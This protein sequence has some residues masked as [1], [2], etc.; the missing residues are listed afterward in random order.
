MWWFPD[1]EF[2]NF[3][4]TLASLV[5]QLVKNLLAMGETWAAKVL[6]RSPR[7]GTSYPLQYSALDNSMD[8]I[9]K[10]W[11]GPSDFHFLSQP[12]CVD[13]YCMKIAS[14]NY[15][16]YTLKH[17]EIE[18]M[19][20]ESIPFCAF[21]LIAWEDLGINFAYSKKNHCKRKNLHSLCHF[22]TFFLHLISF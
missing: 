9:A 15:N 2:I 5:A 3:Y 22:Y 21:S 14:S 19:K 7:E 10:S 1:S 6:E 16:C 8:W 18:Q 12:E 13:S 20:A 4:T 17:D 11:T